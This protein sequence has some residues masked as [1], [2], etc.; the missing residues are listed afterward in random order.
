MIGFGTTLFEIRSVALRVPVAFGLNVT[1]TVQDVFAARVEPQ[2]L[3]AIAKSP[4]FVPVKPIPLIVID[5]VSRFLNVITFGALVVPTVVFGN[6][7][8]VGVRVIAAVPVPVKL[9]DCG[10]LVALSVNVKAA[11]L[12]PVAVGAKATPILQAELAAILDPQVFDVI[13]KSPG[14]VPVTA[15]VETV[16]DTPLLLVTVT[17]LLALVTVRRVLGKANETGDTVKGPL[18][19]PPI[20]I[21]DDAV[22]A[23]LTVS[24]PVMVWLPLVLST[25]PLNICVPWSLLVNV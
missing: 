24:V 25:T 2:V 8:A 22:T 13:T 1:L 18:L 3:E 6:L 16:M 21:L 12:A 23:L 20:E 7:N 5:L 9:T 10:L 17:T 14:F 4:G 19:P 15:T 11:L